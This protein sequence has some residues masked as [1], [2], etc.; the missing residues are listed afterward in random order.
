MLLAYDFPLLSLF[1][2]LLEIAALI[3]VIF[4]IIWAFIDNFT[5]RDHSGWAKAGWAL[6]ILVLPLLGVIIY[7]AARPAEVVA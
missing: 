4:A 6:L 3:V 5:R 1:W 2:V 7:I